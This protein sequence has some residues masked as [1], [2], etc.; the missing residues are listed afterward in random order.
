ML[1]FASYP[2]AATERELASS[3]GGSGFL[4]LESARFGERIQ[5]TTDQPEKILAHYKSLAAQNGWEYR[6]TV[7]RTGGPC[8]SIRYNVAMNVSQFNLDIY[9]SP[10]KPLSFSEPAPPCPET[11]L[12]VDE[13]TEASAPV[14]AT[15]QPTPSP[16]PFWYI[17]Q[18]ARTNY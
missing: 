17:E 6:E 11:P 7:E 10:E 5:R 16:P 18:R 3:A 15:P 13:N 8:E 9:L 1:L 2:G 14:V 12:P 4:G